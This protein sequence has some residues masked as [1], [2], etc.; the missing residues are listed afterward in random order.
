MK[1][2]AV[3][4]VC[5]VCGCP[6]GNATNRSSTRA[7]VVAWVSWG[8]PFRLYRSRPSPD[9]MPVTA[10][11]G[12]QWG[13]EGKGKVVDY[14]AERADWVVR[15]QGGNNAGHTIVVAGETYKLHILPSGVVSG[16]PSVIGNGCV[17]DGTVLLA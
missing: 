15:F 10:V 11:I 5:D 3:C 4:G 9:S 7:R 2:V 8:R 1:E 16:K 14:L 6:G 12:T 13:D 17:V